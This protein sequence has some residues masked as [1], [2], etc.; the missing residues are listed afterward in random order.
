MWETLLCPKT[1]SWEQLARVVRTRRGHTSRV[2]LVPVK[3]GER[4]AYK[5]VEET[6]TEYADDDGFLYTRVHEEDFGG[7]T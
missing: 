1:M 4:A 6:Y 7:H 2:L 5:T 3:G